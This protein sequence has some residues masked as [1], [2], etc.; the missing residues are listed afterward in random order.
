MTVWSPEPPEWHARGAFLMYGS[1]IER[2][3]LSPLGA[4]FAAWRRR[5]S[6]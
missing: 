3:C 2:I 6:A 5:R 4:R 1:R